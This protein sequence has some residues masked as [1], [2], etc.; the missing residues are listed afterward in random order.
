MAVR[1]AALFAVLSV[2][3]AACGEKTAE[4]K[5]AEGAAAPA[6][7][8]AVVATGAC[9]LLTLAEV[10]A[11]FPDVT[12]NKAEERLAD[13]GIHAC[14]WETA[15]GMRAVQV[16]QSTDTKAEEEVG[17]FEAG[18]MDPLKPRK[19][20]P[21]TTIEGGQVLVAQQDA[22][23]GILQSVGVAAVQSGTQT[24]SI[25]SNSIVGRADAATGLGQLAKAAAA[26]AK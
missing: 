4:T 17:T 25:V 13:I 19:A 10:K 7:S 12:T 23:A 26:R 20:L 16:R 1:A 3:L 9:G 11:V 21:R 2:S 5:G 8:G 15:N 14:D 22:D 18:I 6:A 24:V